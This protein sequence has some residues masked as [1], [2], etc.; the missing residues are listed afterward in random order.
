MVV[1]VVFLVTGDGK[2]ITLISRDE[3]IIILPRCRGAL[4]DTA[5]VR[6]SVPAVGARLRL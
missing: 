4:S 6:L 3:V 1:V 2:L 5:T